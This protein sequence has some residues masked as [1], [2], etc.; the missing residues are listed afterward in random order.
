MTIAKQEVYTRQIFVK[1]DLYFIEIRK[2]LELN[3]N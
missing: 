1:T 3:Q 2:L